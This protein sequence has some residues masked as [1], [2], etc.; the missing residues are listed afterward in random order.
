MARAPAEHAQ[1]GQS[2][3]LTST[4]L[5]APAASPAASPARPAP[6]WRLQIIPQ[7]AR[8]PPWPLAP[9]TT[10]HHRCR[11][12]YVTA[13]GTWHESKAASTPRAQLPPTE[14][15][16]HHADRNYLLYHHQWPL[17]PCPFFGTRG[18]D[19]P[20]LF[21]LTPS[22]PRFS[23]PLHPS[24]ETIRSSQMTGGGPIPRLR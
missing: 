21:K 11:L 15:Y 20:C 2:A 23:A 8:T 24:L 4:T 19:L 12:G 6:S 3:R 9:A 1:R 13:R 7:L 22:S 18:T 10:V 17:S 14:A 5:R 16:P